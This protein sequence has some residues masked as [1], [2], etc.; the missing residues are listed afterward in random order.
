MERT[1][2][3]RKQSGGQAATVHSGARETVCKQDPAELG[4]GE[5]PGVGQKAWPA[6]PYGT[7]K[8]AFLVS[9]GL[10]SGLSIWL[11]LSDSPLVFPLPA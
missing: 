4:L 8:M 11:P 3:W 7:C 10:R 5:L 1:P 9:D 2:P 6:I